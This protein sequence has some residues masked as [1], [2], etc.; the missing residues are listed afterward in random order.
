MTSLMYLVIK[1]FQ[2]EANKKGLDIVLNKY[3]F[4]FDTFILFIFL[5]TIVACLYEFWGIK[6]F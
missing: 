2:Y 1:V 5:S 3:K 4:V 6:L